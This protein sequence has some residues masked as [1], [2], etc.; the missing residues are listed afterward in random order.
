MKKNECNNIETFTE[1]LMDVMVITG[2]ILIL[3]ENNDHIG[4]CWA[5]LIKAYRNKTQITKIHK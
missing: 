4:M 1:I 2:I 5:L 3:M